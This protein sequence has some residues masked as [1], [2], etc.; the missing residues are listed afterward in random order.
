L[1]LKKGVPIM[2]ERSGCRST[3]GLAHGKEGDPREHWE[4][5]QL[6]L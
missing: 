3:G 5:L 2:R 4:G 6:R 1:R